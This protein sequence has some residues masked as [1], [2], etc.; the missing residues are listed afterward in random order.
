VPCRD[1]NTQCDRCFG[2]PDSWK[3]SGAGCILLNDAAARIGCYHSELIS[4]NERDAEGRYRLF[5]QS[6]MG[7]FPRHEGGCFE[8]R[9][10]GAA[11]P[12][13]ALG[14]HAPGGKAKKVGF[15]Y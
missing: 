7:R 13:H 14:T 5:L 2:F 4:R 6:G 12:V 11:L 3:F 15:V 1:K 9:F 8:A 10:T